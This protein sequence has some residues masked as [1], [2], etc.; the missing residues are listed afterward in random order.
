MLTSVDRPLRIALIHAA[1]AG[2]GAEV[3]TVS[4]HRTLRRMGHESRLFVGTKLTDEPGVELIPRHRSFPGLL[5]AARWAEEKLGWQYVYHPWF[6]RLDRLIGEA[7][8][9]HFHTLWSGREGYADVGG[10][11]RLSRRYPSLMTLRDLWMLTG[12]CACPQVGCDRWKYGCGS[13]PDLGLAPAVPRDGTQAN[14]ERKR[15]VMHRSHLRVTAVSGWLADRAR[16]SPIFSKADVHVVHNGIDETQFYPRDRAAMRRK[17]RLPEEAFIVL[18]AGQ[19]V[20]GTDNAGG[21]AAE[22]AVAALQL[23]GVDLFALMVGKSSQSALKNWGGQGTAVP[24][25]TDPGALAEYYCAADIVLVA[26]LWETFGRVPAEAQMCGV[27]VAGFATGGIPEIVVTGETGKLVLTGDSVALG[28]AI[29]ILYENPPWRAR[30]G[31]A[32]HRRALEKFSN[33]TV[34]RTFVDHYQAVIA[35]SAKHSPASWPRPT[36]T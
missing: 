6:R 22:L 33:E 30:M 20:E 2:G 21:G 16:E 34:A 31:E 14:W 24:F 29:R 1:D 7:D 28:A 23:S 27:P 18:L 5:R 36:S 9:V 26:S 25:Q 13:C 4:L 19:S 10:L 15:R 11:P 32:A 35:K 3:S 8:V 17:L 12:H